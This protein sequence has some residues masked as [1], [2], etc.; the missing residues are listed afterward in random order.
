MKKCSKC[1]VE[2]SEHHFAKCGKRKDGSVKRRP[3]CRQCENPQI[4]FCRNCKEK[5]EKTEFENGSRICKNCRKISK[6]K[7]RKNK[8]EE[9]NKKKESL[10][11]AIC[12]Y[13]R[14]GASLEF[15][16]VDPSTKIATIAWML[17][18]NKNKKDLNLE[19]AKCCLL[20]SNCH[21]EFHAGKIDIPKNFPILTL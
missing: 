10:G 9:F 19:L 8:T 21:G 20:C 7:Y 13:N 18:K 14:C 2:K 4:I 16:H 1:K 3:K 15:H 6:N 5:L 12:G 17:G 11:C